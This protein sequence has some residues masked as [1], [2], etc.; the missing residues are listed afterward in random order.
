[1]SKIDWFVIKERKN[2]TTVAEELFMRRTVEKVVKEIFNDIDKNIVIGTTTSKNKKTGLTTIK[3]D[4][5]YSMKILERY[6]KAKKEW[7]G[8]EE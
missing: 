2:N 6:L 4:T 8:D 7:L 5:D 3:M 1:M